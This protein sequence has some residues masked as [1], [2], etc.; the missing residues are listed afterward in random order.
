M[1]LRIILLGTLFFLKNVFVIYAT[2][3]T[4]PTTSLVD[5]IMNEKDKED[6]DDNEKD[7]KHSRPKKIKLFLCTENSGIFKADQINPFSQVDLNSQECSK[8]TDQ[9]LNDTQNLAKEY[10]ETANDQRPSDCSVE[11]VEQYNGS[12]LF[13][14]YFHSWKVT[15]PKVFIDPIISY[16]QKLAERLQKEKEDLEKLKQE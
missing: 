11:L 13:K 6:G 8:S 10:I 1:I 5:L 3:K 4:P 2:R 9:K 12:L 7:N 16:K 14:S 15:P